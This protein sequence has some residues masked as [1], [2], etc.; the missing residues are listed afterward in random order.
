MDKKIPV[1]VLVLVVF[2]GLNFTVLF[3]GLVYHVEVNGINQRLGKLGPVVKVIGVFPLL[4]K[5]TFVELWKEKKT[6]LLIDNRFPEIDGFKKNGVL[7]EGAVEDDG[8]LF[9]SVFDNS[10]EQSTVKLIRISDQQI[11]HEWVPNIQEL[12][13]SHNTESPFFDSTEMQNSRYKILH[14][15]LLDD[16]GIIFKACGA[17]L[18]KIDICSNIEWTLDG[19]FHHAIEQD[20]D[21]NLWVPSVIEPASYDKN[22]FIYYRDD[23]VAKVSPG[24]RLLFKKSVSKILEENGYSGLLFGAGPYDKDAIHLNDIQPA[25][26]STE[27]WKKGDLLLSMRHRSTIFLYRPSTNK[28]IWLKTGPWLNQHD[29]DFIGQSKISV[30]GNDAISYP[31]NILRGERRHTKD[32]SVKHNDIYIFDFTD[33]SI[34]TPYSEV[35]KTI[36]V[37]TPTEG[38]QEL[39]ENGDVFVEETDYGRLLRLSSEQVIW[40]FTVRVDDDTIAELQWCRYL[41]QDQVKDILP[42]LEKASCLHCRAR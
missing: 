31:G 34:S 28:I 1:W 9:L 30:F 16:G 21:G 29:P 19:V 14:P 6:P 23:A 42:V 22:I 7:Q 26:Y 2:L 8:Y 25:H 40:E 24:G 18:V 32:V 17:P 20:A 27:Y 35:L 10:K 4:V 11:L 37:R 41:T 13:E 3:G 5:K 36:D 38:L 39:L 33:G 15:F 12:A